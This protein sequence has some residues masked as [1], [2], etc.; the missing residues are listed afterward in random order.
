MLLFKVVKE[1]LTLQYETESEIFFIKGGI[2]E[3]WGKAPSVV[4]QQGI[5]RGHYSRNSN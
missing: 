5:L 2:N 1:I 4:C 3:G